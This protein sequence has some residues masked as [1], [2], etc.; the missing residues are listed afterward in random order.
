MGSTT[1]GG[2]PPFVIEDHD[3]VV[4]DGLSIDDEPTA[5]GGLAPG[6]G[7]GPPTIPAEPPTEPL[8]V[9]IP[10]DPA[11]VAALVEDAGG[12]VERVARYHR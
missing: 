3:T 4:D 8:E 10:R 7:D 6:A 9:V 12:V 11:Q 5:I 2:G 1:V